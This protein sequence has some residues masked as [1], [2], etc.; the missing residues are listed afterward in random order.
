MMFLDCPAYLGQEGA[1]R[2]GLPAEVRCRFTMHSTDGPLDSAMISCPAGHCFSG[3]LELLTPGN[4]GPDPARA[5]YSAGHDRLQRG[6]GGRDGGNE[7]A[8]RDVHAG[9]ARTDRRPNTA[10]AY[11]LGHPASVWMTA[12]RPRRRPAARSLIQ[13]GAGAP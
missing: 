7:T 2:C 3:P 5:G 10:P 6:P 9:P 4:H 12:L 13:A 1:E 11:Y 8:R